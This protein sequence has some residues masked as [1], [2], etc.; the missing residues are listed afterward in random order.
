MTLVLLI[1]D[2]FI[3]Y[4]SDS[5]SLNLHHDSV[6]KYIKIQETYLENYETSID[7]MVDL[8]K[9]SGVIKAAELL[10]AEMEVDEMLKTTRERRK[11]VIFLSF[12]NF[13][14]LGS[15]MLLGLVICHYTTS[16][17]TLTPHK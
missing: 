8:L 9:L 4:L 11:S 1:H 7:G 17:L 3:K 2:I 14:L 10:R 6:V 16:Y 12:S 5:E 15:F 13:E